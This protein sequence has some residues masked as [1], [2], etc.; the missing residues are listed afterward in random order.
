ML[1]N[2]CANSTAET[3]C[4][5]PHNCVPSQLAILNRM[6]SKA[7]SIKEGAEAVLHGNAPQLTVLFFS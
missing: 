3:C 2:R 5:V 7:I 1:D 6:M 4:H